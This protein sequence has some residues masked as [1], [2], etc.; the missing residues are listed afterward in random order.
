MRS[1]NRLPSGSACS[2][3][4]SIVLWLKSP[5][6]TTLLHVVHDVRSSSHCQKLYSY[7]KKYFLK[8]GKFLELR[9]SVEI[10]SLQ[11]PDM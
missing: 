1:M 6:I 10:F 8:Q 4:Q 7:T 3:V 11:V 9:N 2:R 5:I